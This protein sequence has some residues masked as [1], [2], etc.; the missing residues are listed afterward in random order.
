[1]KTLFI[2]IVIICSISLGVSSFAQSDEYRGTQKFLQGVGTEYDEEG[3][4]FDIEYVL[5]GQLHNF[6]LVDSVSKS[7]TFEYDSMGIA[8]DVLVIYLPQRLIEE[9][10]AEFKQRCTR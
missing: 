6:I 4:G 2:F 7:V 10:L 8:E 5:E 9:P 1:M 3:T